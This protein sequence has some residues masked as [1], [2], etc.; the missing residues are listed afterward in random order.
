VT[1]L[2]GKKKNRR[3]SFSGDGE[4]GIL[5]CR[6]WKVKGKRG[7]APDGEGTRKE[8]HVELETP[9]KGEGGTEEKGS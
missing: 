3:L 7:T 4:G 9:E 1:R 5:D 8:P 2:K 6:S